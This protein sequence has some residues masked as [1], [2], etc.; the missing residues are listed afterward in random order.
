MKRL[1]EFEPE[2][3]H[4]QENGLVEESKEGEFT[5]MEDCEECTEQ[6]KESGQIESV[7]PEEYSAG[8]ASPKWETE[9]P[10][11]GSGGFGAAPEPSCVTDLGCG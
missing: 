6:V 7:R 2:K 8:G 5:I 10:L 11:E 3:G 4:E 9:K 1:R